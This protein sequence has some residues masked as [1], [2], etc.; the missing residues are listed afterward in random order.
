MRGP[1][2]ISHRVVNY[3]RGPREEWAPNIAAGPWQGTRGGGWPTMLTKKEGTRV[4]R[5]RV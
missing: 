3:E 2:L 5:G 1:D 4:G